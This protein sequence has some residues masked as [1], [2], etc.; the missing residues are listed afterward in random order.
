MIPGEADSRCPC[1]VCGANRYRPVYYLD[2]VEI[3]QCRE[4]GLI[5]ISSLQHLEDLKRYYAQIITTLPPAAS[6]FE[7][8]KILRASRFRARY[9][10]ESTGLT[11][12]RV[13][14]VGSA[15][16][17]FLAVLQARGF[18]VLGVEPSTQGAQQHRDKGIPVINDL[19][20]HADLPLGQFDAICMFQVFEHFEDPR[21][22]AGRLH[23]LLKPGGFLV[24]EIPDIH[25]TGAKFE[26]RPHRLFNKEHLS[27]FSDESLTAL[28]GQAGF[29][30][31]AAFHYDYDG[32]RIPFLKS[33]KKIL[34]P[35]LK[36]GF[37]GP[38]EKILHQ[39]IKIGH[40][41][42]VTALPSDSGAS[43]ESGRSRGKT[44]RKALT[45]PLDVF[46]GYLAF[47]L[48]RGA[49]LCWVGKKV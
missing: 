41:S 31:V 45:A 7:R 16:G 49:S 46:W 29:S 6:E 10:Q 24:L 8:Q 47:R 20:E 25:S 42:P 38:L 13:L 22:I 18:Q 28:M 32:L 30:R 14:E 44:F 39:E 35:L 11:A 3:V 40:Q 19:L 17:H 48:D 27:Y 34:V 2:E 12:G 1:R 5:Q 21:Q 15:A 9:F 33:L 37:K 23:A 36:P 4:C 26:K 43:S